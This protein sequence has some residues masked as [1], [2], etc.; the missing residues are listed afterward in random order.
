VPG[1]STGPA[2][3]TSDR[4]CAPTEFARD[5]QIATSR[6]SPSRSTPG[7]T[8]P[9]ASQRTGRELAPRVPKPAVFEHGPRPLRWATSSGLVTRSRLL[10]PPGGAEADASGRPD[11]A[12]GRQARASLREAKQESPRRHDRILR[13]GSSGRFRSGRAQRREAVG[14]CGQSGNRDGSWFRGTVPGLSDFSCSVRRCRRSSG[15][16]ASGDCGLR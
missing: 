8:H 7:E 12:T 6:A 2:S 4:S 5:A 11:R 3:L 16:G 10:N 1:E 14:K 15:C 13:E 9:G